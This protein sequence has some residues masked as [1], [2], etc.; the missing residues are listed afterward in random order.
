M[1]NVETIKPFR[2]FC[3][4]IGALPTSYL[5][6]MSYYEMLAWL[7]KYLENTV[8]PAINNN[9]E[10]LKELQSYVANYFDNL[11]VQE[12]INTKLDEMA[13]DGTLAQIINVEMIGDLSNLTTTDKTDLVSAI[14]EVNSIKS[15]LSF[16]SFQTY[17]TINVDDGDLDSCSLRVARNSDGTLC[18]IYGKIQTSGLN[19]TGT[20]TLTLNV[21]TGIRPS[22]EINIIGICFNYTDTITTAFV[23]L[24][25]DGRILIDYYG[26]ANET[27][28]LIFTAC[29]IFV[30]NFGD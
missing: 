4:T 1:N 8:N 7:C 6:S 30:E 28:Q 26:K 11:D 12:E 14:N 18:K 9:A 29:V 2:N 15:Y 22:S 20:K 23:K 21:D 17:T 3:M 10:A 27:N 16:S 24:E 25:T 19:S 5:E 13:G